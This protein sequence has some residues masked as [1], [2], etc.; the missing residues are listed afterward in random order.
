MALGLPACVLTDQPHVG[1]GRD[2]DRVN[3]H[4]GPGRVHGQPHVGPRH[5]RVH[6]HVGRGRIPA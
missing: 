6:L 4:V 2:R 1:R 5:D 3:L